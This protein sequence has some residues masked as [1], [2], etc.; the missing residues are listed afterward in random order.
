[1][2]C[3]RCTRLTVSGCSI[4]LEASCSWTSNDA[5]ITSRSCTRRVR[6]TTAA[7][8]P[9]QGCSFDQTTMSCTKHHAFGSRASALDAIVVW[10]FC[11]ARKSSSSSQLLR[12]TLRSQ[13]CH[14]E[15]HGRSSSHQCWASAAQPSKSRYSRRKRN[16]NPSSVATSS[17]ARIMQSTGPPWGQMLSLTA[18]DV[19]AI[20]RSV[21]VHRWRTLSHNGA[22]RSQAVTSGGWRWSHAQSTA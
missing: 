18:V 16:S 11:P 3:R 22:L 14:V 8:V 19:S 9:A 1:M 4:L 5:L 6:Q 12:R 20:L 7:A 17:T 21:Q 15:R 10:S 13:G 2:R